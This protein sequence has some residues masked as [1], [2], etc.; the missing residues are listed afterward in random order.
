MS[1]RRTSCRTVTAV[2]YM[3]MLGI[4]GGCTSS[5]TFFTTSS[6]NSVTFTN[7]SD[8]ALNVGFFI[9]YQHMSEPSEEF[10]GRDRMQVAP[11]ATVRYALNK[12]P[13]YDPNH[14]PLVHVQV[15]PVTPSWEAPEPYWLELLTAPPVSIV[16]SGTKELEFD[17]GP[18][19][20]EV[21]PHEQIDRHDYRMVGVQD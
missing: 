8:S 12:N 14:T 6:S 10:L 18:G 7:Q 21:I 9:G 16:A 1:R 19:Q 15:Q 5:N 2:G 20:V 3:T 17:A 13:Y 11:G 4:L